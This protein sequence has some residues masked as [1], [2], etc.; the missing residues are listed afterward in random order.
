MNRKVLAMAMLAC[1]G[2]LA[3]VSQA[4]VDCTGEVASLSLQL[5]T[6]GTVTLSLVGGPGYTYL[7]DV[8]GPGR[9]A[10]SATVCRTMY[11]TLM[12]AKMTGKKVTIRFN[13]YNS[14]AAIPA[15]TNSG[16]LGWTELLKD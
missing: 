7:C 12:T 13:D 5:N 6:V 10:V 8:D 11:A 4:V 9:N 15:W 16:S 14:C 3:N 1:S 2:L